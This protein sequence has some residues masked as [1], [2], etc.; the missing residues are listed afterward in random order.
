MGSDLD[1]IRTIEVFDEKLKDWIILGFN[2][3][4]KD[5]IFRI[6]EP[7]GTL[8]KNE[9]GHSVFRAMS[10]AYIGEDDYYKIDVEYIEF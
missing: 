8:V 10:D 1:N 2:G 5:M 6:F 9:L 4:R 7:D 3:L